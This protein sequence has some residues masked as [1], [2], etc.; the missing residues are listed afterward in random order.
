[1]MARAENEEVVY[2]CDDIRFKN[3]LEAVKQDGWISIRLEVSESEQ[4][5]RIQ[6][7][8]GDSWNL[9]WQNRNEISETNLDGCDAS[10][11]R[12]LTDLNLEDVPAV[13]KDLLANGCLA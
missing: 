2:L 4:K 6:A 9:H 7:A 8:Y 11:D 3:E 5:R 10:F 13:V 1:M 12:V